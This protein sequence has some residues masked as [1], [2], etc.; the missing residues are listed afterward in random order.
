MMPNEILE[1]GKHYRLA[2]AKFEDRIVEPFLRLGKLSRNIFS[3][4]TIDENG[5]VKGYVM[6]LYHL[7][8]NDEILAEKIMDKF[9]FYYSKK[10]NDYEVHIATW[11]SG[12]GWIVDCDETRNILIHIAN[13]YEKPQPCINCD[14][15]KIN[16]K[17]MGEDHWATS[18]SCQDCITNQGWPNFTMEIEEE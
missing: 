14:I 18:K 4:R 3:E 10:G 11:Q 6:I 1:V 8:L 13:N 5:D 17:K 2:Q 7:H 9:T 12:K 15:Y 16:V